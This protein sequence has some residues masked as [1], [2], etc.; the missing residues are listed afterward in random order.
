MTAT[1][2]DVLSLAAPIQ[3]TTLM[4][5][6]RAVQLAP[7]VVSEHGAL[8]DNI[9]IGHV[10]LCDVLFDQ[11]ITRQEQKEHDSLIKVLS[12]IKSNTDCGGT[13]DELAHAAF[14]P[15]VDAA[16]ALGLAVG[17]H[18]AGKIGGTQ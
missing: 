3:Q 8:L 18:L 16:Y 9:N 5:L 17:F 14:L 11:Q 12:G 1:L 7:M 4:R 15:I 2:T 10:S 6:A 13:A